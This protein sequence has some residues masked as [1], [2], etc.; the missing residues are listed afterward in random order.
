VQRKIFGAKSDIVTTERRRQHNGAL[1]DV[2]RMLPLRRRR[3][4]GHVARRFWSKTPKEN[5][6]FTMP[7]HR[8]ED[9]IQIG[10]QEVVWGGMVGLIWLR[11]WRDGG[12]F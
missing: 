9:N 6:P 10:L 4:A 1:P 7:R 5:R 12:L 8:W 2:I 11:T 3:W